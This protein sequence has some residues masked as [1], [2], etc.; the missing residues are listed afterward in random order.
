[1]SNWKKISE[2]MP[3]NL[4]EVLFL[5]KKGSTHFGWYHPF[6]SRWFVKDSKASFKRNS[7]LAWCLIPEYDL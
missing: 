6:Y 4:V 3:P 1:M 7:V 5:H 2:E